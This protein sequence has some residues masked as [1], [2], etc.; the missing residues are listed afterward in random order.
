MRVK[1]KNDGQG[2]A[3]SWEASLNGVD[4]LQ[5]GEARI[6]LRGWGYDEAEALKNLDIQIKALLP[7]LQNYLA[8]H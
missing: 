6:F 8:L 7:R 2:R 3:D 1:T 5:F 4:T